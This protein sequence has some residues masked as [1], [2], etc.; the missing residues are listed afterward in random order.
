MLNN[1]KIDHSEDFSTLEN[2]PIVEAIVHWQATAT[3]KFFDEDYVSSLTENFPGYTVG[4]QHNLT[5]GVQGTSAGI[6]INH[7]NVVQGARMT[8]M[9]SGQPEY[10]SQFLRNGVIFSKLAPY[11]NWSSFLTEAQKHWQYFLTVAKP[12]DA[13]SIAVR[14][15]SQIPIESAMDC[16][17]YI[18]QNCA[19]L[20]T[21]GLN[22]NSFYHQ[23]TIL[24]NNHPY[25]I[26]VVRAAQKSPDRKN[27]QIEKRL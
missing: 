23:D 7:S 25:G 24:L 4:Q 17:K 21:L 8:K 6:A 5:T 11:K 1:L 9:T 15:L 22:A 10:V 18:G 2:A 16:N 3:T 20:S 26:S 12:N 19:P 14:Y 13:A 27:H